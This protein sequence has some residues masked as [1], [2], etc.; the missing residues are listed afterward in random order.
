MTA[1]RSFEYQGFAR[2]PRCHAIACIVNSLMPEFATASLAAH[3][4]LYTF[5]LKRC[6]K[7]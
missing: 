1:H 4:V 3:A 5:K 2:Y 6:Q 7:V